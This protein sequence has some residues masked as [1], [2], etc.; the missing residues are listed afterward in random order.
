MPSVFVIGGAR[1]LGAAIATATADRGFDVG[2]T[3]NFDEKQAEVSLRSI[4]QRMVSGAMAQ[5]D[6]AQPEQLTNALELLT[7]DLGMPHAIILNA[8]VFPPTRDISTINEE[9]VLNTIRVNT[10]PIV[11]VSKWYYTHCHRADAV[12]RIVSIGSL[13]AEHIWKNRLA[14]NVS[15]AALSTAVQSL[16]RSCAPRIA[17]NSVAPG[18]IIMPDEPSAND[19]AS[20]PSASIPMMRFGT[21]ND[22]VDAV[23]FFIQATTYIT[24]ETIR[25]D[26]GHHLV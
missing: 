6:V 13:G 19:T 16:A 22:V 24:G 4:R 12:G 26:G 20:P 11:T 1:R 21:T 7:H 9:E 15:K 18:M 10:L 17:I 8:G 23:M 5:A 2:I 14:Y 25:V 3:W